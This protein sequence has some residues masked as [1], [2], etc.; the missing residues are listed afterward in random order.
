MKT[1]NKLIKG[2]KLSI[3]LLIISI[4]L[5]SIKASAQIKPANAIY[6]FNE[7]LMNPAL[8]GREKALNATLGYRKQLTSFSGAPENQFIAIDYGFDT[9][10]AIGLKF[11]NDDAGLLRQTSI[12]ATYAFHLPLN[13]TDKLSFGISAN[14]TDNRLN[15]TLVQGDMNDPE[16]ANFNQ[17]K[18]YFDSDFGL[19]YT[20][21]ELTVQG[22]FPNIISSL[23]GSRA[24]QNNYALFFSAISYKFDTELGIIEPKVAYRGIKGFKNILDVGTNV[25]FE[26]GNDVN[27]NLFG[28][29]HS[30]NNASAGFGINFNQKYSFNGSYTFGTSQL[31]GYSKGDFEVGIG[32]KL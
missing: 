24:N 25:I 23:N 28:L 6:Y 29:Y 12:G 7:F 17:R 31:N 13:Q 27:F 1:L 9:K 32:I 4:Y 22:V 15:N 30:S 8:A 11:N 5:F 14:L 19:A 26:S 16:I 10:S 20:N 3:I 18:V 2:H 21:N